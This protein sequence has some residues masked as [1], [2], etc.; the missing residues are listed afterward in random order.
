[1][2]T[3]L[4]KKIFGSRNDRMIKQYFQSV[5]VINDMESS[6]AQLSDTELRNKTDEFKQRINNGETLDTLLPEAFAVVRET[7]KRTLGMRH[8][9]VQLIGGMVLHGGK[10]SE[11]R[12]GEGKTLMATLPAYLNA[13]SGNGVHIVTVNDYLAKRDAG[14]MGKIYQFL[15]ISVGVIYSHMPH[16]DKQISRMERTMNT[17]LIICAT[18]W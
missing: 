2:L 18:T 4:L 3:N 7:S 8:F 16:E 13:L 9:D 17:G 5:R 11:M 14:W 1:M 6:I 12:T 10:I 15:G